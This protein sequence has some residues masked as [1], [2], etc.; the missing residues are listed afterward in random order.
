MHNF[1]DEKVLAFLVYQVEGAIPAI[2]TL[3]KEKGSSVKARC[4]L[5]KFYLTKKIKVPA[6]A[7]MQEFDLQTYCRGA[8]Y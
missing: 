2:W 3:D 5:T 7:V 1:T 8:D 6:A 4:Y